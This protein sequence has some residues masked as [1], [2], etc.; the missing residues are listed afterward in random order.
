MAVRKPK[1]EL[2]RIMTWPD[3][4]LGEPRGKGIRSKLTQIE[5]RP[6]EE[7]LNSASDSGLEVGDIVELVTDPQKIQ[8]RVEM[9]P[10][11][12]L[13]IPSD[14]LM[15]EVR[16]SALG[17]AGLE[18]SNHRTW[19]QKVPA[20]KLRRTDGAL[21]TKTFIDHFD[22]VPGAKP[23]QAEVK[24]V[25]SLAEGLQGVGPATHIASLAEGDVVVATH[26]LIGEVHLLTLFKKNGNVHLTAKA[27]SKKQSREL[28]AKLAPPRS[29]ATEYETPEPKKKEMVAA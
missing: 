15:V 16:W 9:I 24:S 12:V 26:T 4:A 27:P 1:I 3:G 13:S 19:I 20:W 14:S 8:K 6:V 5:P 11:E 17:S 18:R 2:N 23:D 25:K 28:L 21:E 10:G 29:R 7:W 22:E